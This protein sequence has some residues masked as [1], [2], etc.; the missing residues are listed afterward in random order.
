MFFKNMKSVSF[1]QLTIYEYSLSCAGIMYVANVLLLPETQIK[2]ILI[3]NAIKNEW[4][5]IKDDKCDTLYV[6]IM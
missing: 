4:Y 1:Y 2:I 6:L 3:K 5:A